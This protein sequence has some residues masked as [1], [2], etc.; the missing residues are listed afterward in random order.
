MAPTPSPVD[1]H[2]GSRLRLRRMLIGMSQGALAY[3]LGLTFQQVQKYEKGS[4][5]MG[6]SRLYQIAHILDV[7]IQFF[8]DDVPVMPGE[9]AAPKDLG[10]LGVETFVYDFINTRDGLELIRSFIAIKD[11]K[12]RKRVVDLVRT[13]SDEDSSDQ[14]KQAVVAKQA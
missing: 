13:L 6:A 3:E 1:V 12:V 7:P 9:E 4:N 11:L 5:R 10:K 14:P 2:V 8:F